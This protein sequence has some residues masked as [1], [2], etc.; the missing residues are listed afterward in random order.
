MTALSVE[1]DPVT[2]SR[3]GLLYPW[4]ECL[5]RLALYEIHTRALQSIRTLSSKYFFPYLDS[6]KSKAERQREQHRNCMCFHSPHGCVQPKPGARTACVQLKPRGAYFWVS[7]VEVSNIYTIFRNFFSR[8][9]AGSW[10]RYTNLQVIPYQSP[11]S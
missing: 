3:T 7:Y 1:K 10:I 9:S 8:P 4:S 2:C 5:T 6:S 11:H